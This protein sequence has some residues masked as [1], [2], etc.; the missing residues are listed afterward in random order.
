M[1]STWGTPPHRRGDRPSGCCLARTSLIAALLVCYV[2][3]LFLLAACR[4]VP[5]VPLPTTCTIN[6]PGGVCR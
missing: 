2:V 5:Y 3:V 4:P 6:H 1:G